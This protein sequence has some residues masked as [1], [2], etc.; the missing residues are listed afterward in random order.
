MKVLLVGSGGREHALAWKLS[1]SELLTGLLAAPGNPGIGELACNLPGVGTEDVTA[2][3]DAARSHGVDLVV[4]GP[5]AP[6]GAGM[7]D[8]LEAAGVSAFGPTAA[9]ARIE[10][11]KAWAKE[12]MQRHGIP[13]AKHETFHSPAAARRYL[14]S[15]PEGSAVVKADGLA[16]GK[17][18]ALP[19]TREEAERAVNAMM[20]EG[21]FGEAGST[22]VIEERLSGVEVSVF[23]FVCGETVSAE[24]A[25]CDYKRVYSGDAGPNTGGMG[26]YSPPEFWTDEL[27]LAVRREI[28]EPVAAAMAAEGCPY[29]GVIYAGLMAT[30]SGPKVIEFNCRFGDPE[31]QVILPRLTTDLLEVCAAVA[32]DRLDEVEVAWGGS[33]RVAVVMASGGYPVEYR[34]GFPITGLDEAAVTGLPFHAGTAF[35]G[36]GRVVTA[37]GRVL[38]VVGS[39]KDVAEARDRAYRSVSAVTFEGA[40]YRTDIAERAV[41]ALA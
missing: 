15:M 6:L 25:A 27:S 29:R 24:V 21:S 36:D 34:T 3:V 38:A 13:T 9:A 41:A 10:S 14:R 11:S 30:S 26:S 39:G 31:T 1:R 32:G 7:V 16:A 40:H 33:A 8:R 5:E 19:D 12:L 18:V 4:V 35:D 2:V 37:G 22:V 17:G 28:L 20:E 23:A